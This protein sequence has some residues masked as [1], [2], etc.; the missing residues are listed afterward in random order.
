[1]SDEPK[2]ELKYPVPNKVKNKRQIYLWDDNKDY[3]DNLPN[4]SRLVN[5]LLRK[6]R[7]END[8]SEVK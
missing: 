7:A 4:K 6:Y 3:Y 2:R 5:L 1:M 8:T